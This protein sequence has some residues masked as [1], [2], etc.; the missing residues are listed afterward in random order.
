MGVL[1]QLIAGMLTQGQAQAPG[2]GQI[3]GQPQGQPQLIRDQLGGLLQAVVTML[4][5]PRTGGLDGLVRQFQQAGLGDVISS[6]IGTGQ[7]QPIDPT[8]LERVFPNE[9]T[10]MSQKAGLP[11]QQ[12]GSILA[13]ILP[14]L[15]D[16]LTPKGQI[17]PQNQMG[18]LA[19]QLLKSLLR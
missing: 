10:Q 12:G 19:G 4:S 2:Q 7:N 15:I 13:Q 3:P 8:Q 17:P 14:Q 9:V 16:Q 18:D 11:P 5:D 6:W 1:E